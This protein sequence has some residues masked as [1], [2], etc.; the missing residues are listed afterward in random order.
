MKS[1]SGRRPRRQFSVAELLA[2][3]GHQWVLGALTA[4]IKIRAIER[5]KVGTLQA[6]AVPALIVVSGREIAVCGHIVHEQFQHLSASLNTALEFR[7][8]FREGSRFQISAA[9]VEAAKPC[10]APFL[11]FIK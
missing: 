1:S 7:V 8:S 10:V 4:D 11:G 5:A 9:Q 6:L 2:D 3:V